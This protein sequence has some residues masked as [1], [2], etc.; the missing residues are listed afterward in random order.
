MHNMKIVHGLARLLLHFITKAPYK[1][2]VAS[3]MKL[4]E[5]HLESGEMLGSK[6]L[7]RSGD[8]SEAQFDAYAWNIMTHPLQRSLVVKI[9]FE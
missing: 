1:S 8:N 7:H 9:L 5:A 6:P 3:H 4:V 2:Y